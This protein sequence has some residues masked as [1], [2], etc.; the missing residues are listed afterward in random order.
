VRLD[1]L[2]R[3]HVSRSSVGVTNQTNDISQSLAAPRRR[4]SRRFSVQRRTNGLGRLADERQNHRVSP[5]IRRA[6]MAFRAGPLCSEAVGVK[7]AVGWR[8]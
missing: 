4:F 8:L 7:A 5:R 3:A 2:T 1:R 6:Q